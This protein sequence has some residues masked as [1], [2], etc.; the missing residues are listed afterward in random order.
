MASSHPATRYLNREPPHTCSAD[1]AA[2]QEVNIQVRSPRCRAGACRRSLA[3]M[4][5]NRADFDAAGEGA[6]GGQI[7]VNLVP[8]G[9]IDGSSCSFAI[10]ACVKRLR[11]AVRS[12]VRKDLA[13]AIWSVG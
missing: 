8:A 3:V 12:R 7:W 2:G 1:A 5:A 9:P 13:D 6:R 11:E 4:V 10:E